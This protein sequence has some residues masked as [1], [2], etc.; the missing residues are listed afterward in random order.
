MKPL[1]S[2]SKGFK[3]IMDVVVDMAMDMAIKKSL[4]YCLHINEKV[5]RTHGILTLEQSIKCVVS[6]HVCGA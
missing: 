3:I 1:Y 2:I 6:K 5:K 4:P